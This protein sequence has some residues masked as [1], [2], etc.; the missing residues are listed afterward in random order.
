[1]RYHHETVEALAEKLRTG[2][3]TAKQQAAKAWEAAAAAH[4]TFITTVDD[5]AAAEI[6]DE[7]FQTQ[8]PRSALEGI[9]IAIKDV[10]ATAGVRTTMGS[11]LFADHVP[12]EDAQIVKQLKA[13][14]A[15]IVGKSNTHE[16][17][18]GI[19]GDSTAFGV[20][21]NPY[22]E[23]R[24]AGGSSS[25]SAAAVAR[26]IVPLA[27][28]SDTAGSIRVPAAL[29]GAVGFKPTYDLLDTAGIFPLAQSFDTAGFLST[30]VHDIVI[31]MDAIG[32]AGCSGPLQDSGELRFRMLRGNPA[33]N[34]K[35]PADETAQEV[36]ELLDAPDVHHPN[37]DGSPADF[38]GLFN[39][40]RSREAYAVHKKYLR[41]DV[42]AAQ[43]QELT[44]SRLQQGA[45]ITDEQ[46]EQAR[47][48]IEEISQRYLETFSDVD[49]LLSTTVPLKAP[50]RSQ[51]PG[52]GS[53]E[54]VS[55]CVAWNVLGWPALT[56]PYWSND[57]LL[58]NAIQVI[59]KPGRD[60][61][62]LSAG[63]H[64]E[65]LLASHKATLDG[66]K[67]HD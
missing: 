10:I 66:P 49:I 3:K 36:P 47:K 60:T 24:I 37:F 8:T 30:T 65:Q 15:N 42:S 58:P 17:S 33:L 29:C 25:G 5:D 61:D 34:A 53:E 20:V 14:G 1:M 67:G 13:A 63:K 26:G 41:C 35:I 12:T 55:Q 59:G 31:A 50:P 18:F 23:T 22:D 48:T 38:R 52:T 51:K 64:I 57:D 54:L 45:D 21:P 9:P 44:Y 39:T 11:Q 4:P 43:Y 7:R 27:V 28:G 32:A 6:S 16:F 2:A 40:I 56:V 19:R 46:V 62:V